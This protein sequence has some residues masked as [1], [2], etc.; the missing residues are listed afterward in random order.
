MFMYI[1]V[2]R[3]RKLAITRRSAWPL[4]LRD[5]LACSPGEQASAGVATPVPA[6]ERWFRCTI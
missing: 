5:I 2:L 3:L 4:A 1:P 6:V